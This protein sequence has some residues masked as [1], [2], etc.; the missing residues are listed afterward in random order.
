MVLRIENGPT[1]TLHPEHARDLMLAQSPSARRS[2]LPAAPGE[3]EVSAELGWAGLEA[4][5]S[6]GATR[7]WLG[8][9]WLKAVE[10]VTG[11]SSADVAQA[12]AAV[13]AAK[14][15]GKVDPG[16]YELDADAL[17]ALAGSGR[18]RAQMAAGSAPQLVLVHGTFVDTASTFARLWQVHPQAVRALFEHYGAGR[19][20]ALDHPTLG[21]SPIANALTLARACRP[22][23]RLHL[24]THSRGGLVAE[25]LARVCARGVGADELALFADRQDE[26]GLA[27]SY[28]AHRADLAALAR[29]VKD[30]DIR[31][32]RVVRVACPAHGTLLASKRLDAYLSVLQWGLDLAQVPVLPELVDFLAEVARRR[33]RPNELPGLEAMTPDS[34]VLKWLNGPGAPID[35]QLRVVAGDIEGDSVLTWAKTL[36][37]DAFYWTD[38]DLVVQTRSMYGGAPRT[39]EGASF[40]LDRGGKVTHFN[41]FAN[42]RT[43]RAVVDGLTLPRP[44]D[45]RLIGPLSWSGASAEGTRAARAV[46]RS[47]EDAAQRPAAFVLPGILGSNL[48]LDG[49]RVWLGLR[50]FNSLQDLA[51][52]DDTARRVSDDG[53]IGLVYDDLI[54]HLAAT[55]EVIPFGFDWRRPIEDEARRLADAVERAL[56]ARDATGRPVRIVAHSMG[57][58][59]AR[60]M[61]LERPKTWQRMMQREGARVLMLGTPNG[62]SWAPMQVMSGD[63]T[64]GNT[65]A[66]LGSLFDNKGA[67]RTMA[68]MP[69]FIQLQAALLD[70]ALKLD[71]SAT[72]KALADE[73]VKRL[74]ERSFWHTHPLSQAVY[75]WS[76]PP[77]AVLAGAVA[78]RRRLD[79]QAAALDDDA[80]KMLLVVG[81]AKF[82][83]AGIR[84]GEDG[85][86]YLDAEDGDG[87]VTL[88]SAMLPGVRTW[89][90]DAS[91]GSLPGADAAFA[92]YVELLAEGDTARLARVEGV[93]GMR[94][95]GGVPA[96]RASRPSRSGRDATPPS[97]ESDLYAEATEVTAAPPRAALPLAVVNGDIKFIGQALMM[98]HYLSST[99]TGTEGVVDRLIGGAMSESLRAGNY[100]AGVGSSLVFANQRRD[101]DQPLALPRPQAAV[102]VGLGEEGRLTMLQLAQTVEKGAVAYAQRVAEGEGGAPV[103]FELA[104]VLIGSGGTGVSAGSAAQ[105]IAKGIAA[106]N[107]RLAAVQWPQVTR[108]HLVE[109]YLDRAS[110]AHSALAV[111]EE[112]R[113]SEF[114]LEAMVRTGTGARRRPPVWGYR[115]ASYDFISARQ[116]KGDQGEPLIEYTLDTQRARNEVRGQATQVQLVDEL[117]RTGADAGSGDERLRRSLF[118]LLVPV[119]IEPFLAASNA[120]VLQLDR[121][122]A[123]FPWELLDTT[124]RDQGMPWSVRT[125]M[126]RKLRTVEFRENPVGARAE[127]GALVIGEPQCD[128][129]SFAPLPAARAEAEAVAQALQSGPPLLGPDALATVNALLDQPW[130]IVHIAGHGEIRDDY[131]GV[132]LSNETLLGPNE[133]NAMR[134]VPELVFVNCCHI[135]QI[136]ANPAVRRNGLGPLRSKFAAGVAEQLIRIGVRCVVA[137]GWAVEDKPAQ[138]FAETF[139]RRVRDGDRFIDAVG[140]AREACWRERPAGNTWAAYQCYGDPEWVLG[141]LARGGA[142]GA[143]AQRIASAPALALVLE[144][145]ALDAQFRDS[146]SGAKERRAQRREQI[147][148]LEALHA[149]QWGAIG[150]VAEAFGLAY[151]QNDDPSRAIDWYRRA[152]EAADGSASF[153][154]AEQLG[155]LMARAG[156]LADDTR[157]I[158]Q[159]VTLLERVALLHGTV[160]RESLLGS[161]HKR[162]ALL[163]A[164]RRDHA[165][166]LAALRASSTHYAQAEAQARRT[167]ADNLFYPA[168]N[169][170]AVELR[171]ALAQRQPIVLDAARVSGVRHSLQAKVERDPD[172]WSVAG[173]GELAMLEAMAAGR[174]ADIRARVIAQV[175]D[176]AARVP[177]AWMWDS[178]LAQARFTLEPYARQ[179]RAA[180]KQ[181]A[182]ALLAELTT[183][184]GR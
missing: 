106:A 127:G 34:P 37:S 38:N 126:L 84:M 2:A 44:A 16:V 13:I 166:E 51:W 174:L 79:A 101:P 180:E 55:H 80:K 134:V 8:K 14:V 123:R 181:A 46:A 87:R 11:V 105:A 142:P 117:V 98:G 89:R 29:L 102:I 18:K 100:P 171:L 49:R 130:R 3:V 10:V 30:N 81:R 151:A 139:Y 66:A 73:D 140:A 150:A 45:F 90:V 138:V 109:L 118:Q 122:S 53:P 5:A 133:I 164:K 27:L 165:A 91:H 156:E 1:L 39:D 21:A 65:L 172:F 179:S 176:L 135:G 162:A 48:A 86:E 124:D 63:D 61:R 76:A 93:G 182:H 57:G 74:R 155:N 54:E 170:I 77:D 42:E 149:A 82:T 64:F 107:R 163:H 9:V 70:E 22:G 95:A 168:M 115:G 71:R 26:D 60:T 121:E 85:L 157:P 113:P 148:Q 59:V 40:V 33:M 111:L 41:Y 137:A 92:A 159:A 78:L 52:N 160:E 169:A 88:D 67:R 6:R 32:E 104:S 129:K 19:V 145:S 184:A 173:V 108:L 75:E 43:V 24:V 28:A 143:A 167:G 50:F 23:A 31:V 99:L 177:A 97:L 158:E 15:D 4:A 20:F 141:G 68:G 69:G 72:W 154:A 114:Q 132:V 125:K 47:R 146:A 119:E 136:G 58:L 183:L 103:G 120:I 35:G 96:L 144:A 56:D 25:V 94:G 12:S 36:L 152:L 178:L 110:E 175:R 128:P 131:G 7:G 83:P 147:R 116:F 161:T 17:G 62:G 112:A 153:K